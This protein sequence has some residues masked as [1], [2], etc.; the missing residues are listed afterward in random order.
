MLNYIIILMKR[1]NDLASNQLNRRISSL[2]SVQSQA[3]VHPGW[4]RFMRQSLQ[5]TLKQLAEKAHLSLP[6]IAQAE[7]GEAAGKTSLAT[8]KTMA[9][10]MDCEL[11]YAFVPKKDV[12]EL[13]EN[14]AFEK[15]KKIL[16]QADVHMTLEDQQV[17]LS[18]E[19]RVN[20]L[21]KKLLEKGDV[22]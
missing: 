19:E 2:R 20:Q 11:M 15:A 3:T 9:H 22:W 21:A 18:F 10:A 6:T 17:T 14:A 4:I 8:L 5:M 12:S 16:S 1:R 13:I 7:R